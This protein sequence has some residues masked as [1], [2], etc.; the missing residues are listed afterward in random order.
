MIDRNAP[1]VDHLPA[2][3][4]HAQAEREVVAR[5][6]ALA[7]KACIEAQSADRRA[8]I[9][10]VR[11]LQ[12][13]DRSRRTH[14]EMM[15]AAYLARAADDAHFRTLAI[16]QRTAFE[17]PVAATER[18]EFRIFAEGFVDTRQPV[19]TRRGVVVGDRDNVAARRIQPAVERRDLAAQAGLDP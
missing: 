17:H 14:A 4:P 13:R 9:N 16:E 15:V 2:R 12:Q 8:S 11:A 7:A 6:R 5:L 1:I 19:D 18:T 3:A 10:H